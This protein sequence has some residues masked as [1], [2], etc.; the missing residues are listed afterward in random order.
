MWS[1]TFC[2]EGKELKEVNK[3]RG[4]EEVCKNR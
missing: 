1:E 2:W 4:G 3:K